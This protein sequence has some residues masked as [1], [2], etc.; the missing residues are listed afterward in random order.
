MKR[1]FITK[2]E[3]DQL[4]DEG[5]AVLEVDD[6]T[7]VTDLAREYAMQRGLQ[8]VHVGRAEPDPAQRAPKT[9]E[10]EQLRAS[11]RSAVIGHLG[12]VPPDLEQVIGRVLEAG[13]D[14]RL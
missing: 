11:V 6:Q 1:H 8:L 14:K 7:T 5:G 4:L 3:I 12:M 9:A 13:R 2:A 10:A